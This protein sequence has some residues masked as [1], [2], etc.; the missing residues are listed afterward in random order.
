MDRTEI[1]LGFI[2]FGEAAARFAA[3]LSAAGLT[4]IVAYS[5]S[6]AKVAPGDPLRVR[7]GQAGV[8]LQPSIRKVCERANLIIAL[9]PGKAALSALRKARSHLTADHV[10][11]DASTASVKDMEQAARML[12]GVA[13]FVDAALMEPVPQGGIRTLLVASGPKA[14]FVRDT[15]APYGMN[16]QVVSDKP[17]AASAMK[18]M[19]SVCTKGLAALLLE[20]L[21]A[22]QRYGITDAV[23]ADMIRFVDGRPF[24]DIIKRFVCGTAIHAERRIHEMSESL[25]LLRSLGGSTRMTR[26]T[27]GMLQ[28]IVAMG[29]RERFDAREPATIAPV[30][31]AIIESR[32]AGTGA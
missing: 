19:R 22:A 12:E 13:H 3:D 16:I 24:E 9:T 8:E 1:R 29:L 32:R 17:G 20:S 5:R 14:G 11:V 6:G 26:A 4:G 18:L 30:L 28:E 2:G 7:A 15:L 23:A 10:Y 25:T 31:E 21:E 27:R